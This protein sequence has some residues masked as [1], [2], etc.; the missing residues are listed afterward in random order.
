MF[1][2]GEIGIIIVLAIVL[3][4]PDKLP[5]AAR[6]MGKIYAEYN[7]AKKRFEMEVFYGQDVPQKDFLEKMSQNKFKSLKKDITS[8][9]TDTTENYLNTESHN[10]KLDKNDSGNKTSTASAPS[11]DKDEADK[12]AGESKNEE[13]QNKEEK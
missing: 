8:N 6:K 11:Q 7:N 3:L 5:E 1:G 4:G 13:K 12:S 2:W 10:N 9:I